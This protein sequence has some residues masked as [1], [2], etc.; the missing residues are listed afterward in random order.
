V[1]QRRVALHRDDAHTAHDVP[2]HPEQPDRIAAI[3]QALERTGLIGRLAPLPSR[4]ATE[5]ELR[6]VHS[7]ELIS[8][9]RRLDAAGGAQLDPD[10]A[11]LSGSYDAAARAV[12]GAVRRRTQCCRER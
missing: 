10:T 6:L 1:Q 11:V 7:D 3:E 2:Y 12:G 8:L 9:L 4:V 5:E